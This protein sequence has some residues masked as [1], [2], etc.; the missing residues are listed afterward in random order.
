AAPGPHHQAHLLRRELAQVSARHRVLAQHEN[1]QRGDHGCALCGG[2]RM[3]EIHNARYCAQLTITH[4][5]EMMTSARSSGRVGAATSVAPCTSARIV[6]AVSAAVAYFPN[7][8]G[9]TV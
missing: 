9:R 3:S 8:N 2:S 4:S 5:A 6:V 1:D 7:R